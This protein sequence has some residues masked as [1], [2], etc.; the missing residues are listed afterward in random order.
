MKVPFWRLVTGVI[1]DI[2]VEVSELRFLVL[3]NCDIRGHPLRYQNLGNDPTLGLSV[4]SFACFLLCPASKT[5]AR[6]QCGPIAILATR[7]FNSSFWPH[8][9]SAY[10]AQDVCNP[11]V[12]HAGTS[13]EQYKL[14][15]KARP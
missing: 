2:L 12:I 1:W 3:P 14:V 7:N 5:I 13:S 10:V 6:S 4:V 15:F 8:E 9:D 11:E